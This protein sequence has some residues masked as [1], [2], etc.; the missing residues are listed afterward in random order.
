[1]PGGYKAIKPDDGTQFSKDYQPENRGRKPKIFSEIFAEFKKSGY[2]KATDEHI[3]DT[4]QQL[5]ALPLSEVIAIAGNPKD[6]NGYPSVM[7]LMARAMLDT[8]KS[9]EVIEKMLNRANGMPKSSIDMNLSGSVSVEGVDAP[10]PK[11]IEKAIKALR[12]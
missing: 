8:K 3:R 4:Y 2:E 9:S 6:E 7:R 11:A 12:G 1:M 10:D 5:L